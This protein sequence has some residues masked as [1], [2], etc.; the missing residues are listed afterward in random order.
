M[1]ARTKKPKKRV[2][3][4]VAQAVDNREFDG[5]M[6]QV[7]ARFA[8]TSGQ[9]LFTTNVGERLWAAYLAAMPDEQE[10]QHHTCHA[11]RSFVKLFGGLVTIDE[12]GKTT[13]AIWDKRDA[14]ALYKPAVM[15][16]ARLVRRARVTDVFLSPSRQLGQ[17]VT[18]EW[19]HLA[20]ALD[21]QDLYRDRACAGCRRRCNPFRD[22]SGSPRPHRSGSA[23][24]R[25]R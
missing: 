11:C 21:T 1:T 9:P 5:F 18:G 13:P 25:H 3:T 8:A 23:A 2:A 24:K 15:A 12:A 20:V 16:M 7:Q 4:A 6:A 14:P 10:R 19:H 22:A 17:P